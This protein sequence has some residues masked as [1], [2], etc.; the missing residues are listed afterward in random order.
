ML[1]FKNISTQI[2]DG[3]NVSRKGLGL[4]TMSHWCYMSVEEA[5]AT[6][7]CT[8][9]RQTVCGPRGLKVVLAL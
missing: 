9:S 5:P 2:E 3:G 4:H 8:R 1:W 6:M 7:V